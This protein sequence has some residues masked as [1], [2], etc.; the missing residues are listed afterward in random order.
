MDLTR[1][2]DEYN[3]HIMPIYDEANSNNLRIRSL[4]IEKLVRIKI[5]FIVVK[6]CFL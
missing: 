4:L 3:K 2:Q 5:G 6:S 1:I